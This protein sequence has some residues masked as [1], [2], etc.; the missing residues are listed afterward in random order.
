VVVRGAAVDWFEEG[1]AGG[2]VVRSAAVDW[3][4]KGVA[5]VGV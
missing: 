1:V 4:E 5:E 3:F 2:V